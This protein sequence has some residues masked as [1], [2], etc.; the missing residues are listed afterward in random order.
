M[1][2]DR[3]TTIK[4]KESWHVLGIIAEFVETT[5]IL[6]DI[7]PAVSIFG[8][9][10]IQP[11]HP[12]YTETEILARKLSDAGFAILSGGGPGLMEAANKGAYAG[13]SP[14]VGLN[15]E[16]PME[17]HD[18]PYQNVSL[19]FRHFFARKVA[20]AKYAAAFVAVPG[21]WGTLDELMEV[22]TLI[23]TRVTRR[24]PVILVG[25]GF[26]KG[27]L[28]W[29]NDTQVTGGTVSPADMQ[30]IRV[31]DDPDQVVEAIFDFYQQ[32]GFYAPTDDRPLHLQL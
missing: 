8:S 17:Q 28:D 6:A 7:R 18:N 29:M 5:E 25:S 11:G 27:L 4:A 23:Q 3:A 1:P 2:D 14:S 12:W 15:M 13:E 32:R 30:L 16:L 19:H 9:A 10:R 21:G 26:W 20:F 22:L 24:I 31:I